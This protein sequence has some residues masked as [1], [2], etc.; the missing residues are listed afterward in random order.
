MVS[1]PSAIA[2]AKIFLYLSLGAATLL[3]QIP[4]LQGPWATP[5]FRQAWLKAAHEKLR[6]DSE[7]LAELARDLHKEASRHDPNPLAPSVLEQVQALEKQSDELRDTVAKLDENILSVQVI[8]GAEDIKK[9]ARALEDT[10]ADH[11]AAKRLEKCRRLSRE[12]AKQAD[13]IAAGMVLP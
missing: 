8:R 3:A 12:I 2:G 11:P 7:H 4:D 6:R 9:Q 1:R 10:F 13:A 5:P